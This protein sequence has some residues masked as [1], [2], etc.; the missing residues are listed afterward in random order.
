M[1]TLAEIRARLLEQDEGV[2]GPPS[3]GRAGAGVDDRRGGVPGGV[4]STSQGT[5]TDQSDVSPVS[6]SSAKM[7]TQTICTWT[8]SKS[9]RRDRQLT[10]AG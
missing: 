7:L 8:T 5:V 10:G 1:T 6:K 2:P 3:Q 4:S 9:G